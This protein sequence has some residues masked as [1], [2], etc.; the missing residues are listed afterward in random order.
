MKYTR[1]DGIPSLKKAIIRYTEEN[2]GRLVAPENVI[3]T[4]G[5]KQ[6]I[7]NILYTLLNLRTR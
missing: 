7:F 2:Y 1:V 4:T 5:A 6:S 3:V